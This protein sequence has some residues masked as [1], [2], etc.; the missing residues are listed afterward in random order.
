MIVRAAA[1]RADHASFSVK[2]GP[3]VDGHLMEKV[4][5]GPGPA[6]QEGHQ[7]LVAPQRPSPPRRSASPFA[8]HNGRKFVPV[9]VTENMVGHKLG[10]FAPTRTFHGHSSRS[11]S[12]SRGRSALLGLPP[13]GVGSRTR[14]AGDP[15]PAARREL[16][17]APQSPA[18]RVT[19]RPRTRPEPP[20]RASGSPRPPCAREPLA[21]GLRARTPGPAAARRQRRAERARCRPGG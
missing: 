15:S 12:G 5:A 9:F 11:W 1:R 4:A 17:R 6:E 14:S 2:K 21:P 20:R 19:A 10:E 7:D 13:E 16:V 8:V 18:A 3:F